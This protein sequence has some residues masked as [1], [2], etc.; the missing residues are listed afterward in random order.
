MRW[1]SAPMDT[2]A[3]GDVGGP[4]RLWDVAD[5]AHPQPL[6]RLLASSHG[7]SVEAVAFSPDGHTLACGNL[8]GTVQ[9]WNVADPAHP[10]RS[11]RPWPAA[12]RVDAVAFSPDGHTLASGSL[13]RHGP[14]VGCRRPAHTPGRS[15]SRWPADSAVNAVA[16]SPDGHTL[17]GASSDGITRLWNL[18]V[19]YAIERIC[20]AAGG[21]TP[22]QW[23]TYIPKLRY[24]SACHR[25][26]GSIDAP[27]RQRGH[28]P[29]R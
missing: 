7:D 22:Q 20:V 29:G 3:S 10:G 16:F 17:A 2:L 1:R 25:P 11:A 5:P 18:N 9:L 4:V 23:H 19:D 14:A 21:L 6:G 24:Q 8:D 28:H 26:K 27:S 15:A 12:N 13:R